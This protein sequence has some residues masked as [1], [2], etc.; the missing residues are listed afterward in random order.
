[1][2]ILEFRYKDQKKQMAAL[3]FLHLCHRPTQK[4]TDRIKFFFRKAMIPF[5]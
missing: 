1:M 3:I 5:L 2:N 4:H